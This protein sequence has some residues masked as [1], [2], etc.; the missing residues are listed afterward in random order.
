[1]LRPLRSVVQLRASDRTAAFVAAY[2]AKPGSPMSAVIEALS[3]ID[4]PSRRTGSRL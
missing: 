1:M 2:T 3:T 4:A